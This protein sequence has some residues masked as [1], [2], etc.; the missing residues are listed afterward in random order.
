[1]PSGSHGKLR[2]RNFGGRLGTLPIDVPPIDLTVSP[3]SREQSTTAAD[4]DALN[5]L[6]APTKGRL[7]PLPTAA[8][9]AKFVADRSVQS[10]V[11]EAEDLWNKPIALVLVVLLLT[12]EWLIR[13]SAGLI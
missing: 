7:I 3:P 11:T 13:K 1:M 12:I 10:S 9:L 5:S 4:F 6:V 2:R 8:D